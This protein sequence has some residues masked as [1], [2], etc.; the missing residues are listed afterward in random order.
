MATADEDAT[1]T[2][3]ETNNVSLA[4]DADAQEVREASALDVTA[5]AIPSLDTSDDADLWASWSEPT[6]LPATI[7]GWSA[8]STQLIL[9]TIMVNEYCS[10]SNDMKI[11]DIPVWC[12]Y[13]RIAPRV[14]GRSSEALA[15]RV[16]LTLPPERRL[17]L[18]ASEGF[19]NVCDASFCQGDLHGAANHRDRV[20]LRCRQPCVSYHAYGSTHSP[21]ANKVDCCVCS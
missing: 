11:G 7:W 12:A 3:P 16:N 18:L 5:D 6:P 19:S 2:T 21:L 9:Q 17:F 10:K 15:L 13:P 1:V 8:V 20:H 14:D 4:Q